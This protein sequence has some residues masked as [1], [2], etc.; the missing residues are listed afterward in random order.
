MAMTA[1]PL[2]EL[3]P[4]QSVLFLGS[5]FSADATNIRKQKVPTG[6]Q[7]RDEF[8]KLLSVKSD[9]YDLK[10]LADEIASRPEIDLY[11]I[12][13]EFFTI[14]QLTD[15]QKKILKLPWLRIYTT[16]YDDTIEFAHSVTGIKAPSFSFDDEKPKKLSQTAVIHLHGVIRKANQENILHQLVL[17]EAAYVRQHFEKSTWYDDFDRDLRFCNACFFVGYSLSDYH[18]AALLMKNKSTRAK[19]YFITYKRYDK[20]FEARVAPYG[21]ILPIEVDGFAQICH[22]APKPAPTSSPHALKAFRFL[23]PF[24]D[25][26]SLAPPTPIEILNLVTYGTFNYDRCL[27]TLPK[28]EYIVPRE[29]LVK[30]AV[31]NLKNGKCLLIHSRIGNGK[32]IFLYALA[33]ALSEHGYH[34]FLCK[35]NAIPLPQDM[36]IL[37]TFPKSAIL[38]DSY[39]TA[40]EFIDHLASLPDD[41]KIVVAVR[42]GVQEVRLHEIQSK[43]PTPLRRVNL[44]GIRGDEIDDFK[45]L[46]NRSGVRAPWLEQT[47]EN[48]KDFREVVVTLYDNEEIRRK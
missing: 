29:K 41:V 28:A 6:R 5:G 37:K 18:I 45:T 34:C 16:N 43:L 14:T 15:D 11:K 30:E 31:A 9:D 32:T 23:D 7:L 25:K 10:T 8:A 35:P 46:L 12:L 13:Y 42:T 1:V 40:V 21:M 24:K 26:K 39:N 2:N 36:D 19:T 38:F 22:T 20:L 48:C 4:T 44:N 3:D 27:S 33:N 47:I 17:N